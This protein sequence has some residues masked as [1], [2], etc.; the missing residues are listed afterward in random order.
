MVAFPFISR[1]R[2]IGHVGVKHTRACVRATWLNSKTEAMKRR[3]RRNINAEYF[4]FLLQLPRFSQPSPPAPA[5]MRNACAI[6][7]LH[8]LWAT[9]ENVAR[10]PNNRTSGY[11]RTKKEKE[12]RITSTPV[13]RENSWMPRVPVDFADRPIDSWLIFDGKHRFLVIFSLPLLDKLFS[14]CNIVVKHE[15]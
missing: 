2:I 13:K 7:G 14:G 10:R 11:S 4:G 15:W 1:G 6:A 12:K 3:E 8:F 5:L 9:R